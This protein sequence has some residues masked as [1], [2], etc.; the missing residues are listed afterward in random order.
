[1]NPALKYTAV[2]VVAG[3]LL[4][5]GIALGPTLVK[6]PLALAP[7]P[8]R[9]FE[10][11][12]VIEETTLGAKTD[13]VEVPA[14]DDIELTGPE[15]HTVSIFR[16]AS[17][18]VVFITRLKK[19]RMSLD[20]TQVKSGSGS[21]IIWDD[22]GH[23]VTNHHVIEGTSGARVTLAD[24]STYDAKVVGVAPDKDLAV[25]KID[26][27]KGKLRGLKI[28]TS[29]R[30]LVGQH[31]YAIGN[32]FGLDHTLS[33]GVISG[34]NREI[35][36]R[37]AT[38]ITGVV[39]TDA[40]INPGNS[41]GPLLDSGGR[42]IGINT[43]IYSPSGASAGIGFAVPVDTVSRIVPQ[44]I[45]HGKI[46]K[47]GLGVTIADRVRGVQG[48]VIMDVHKGSGAARAGL[49]P[50]L[51]DKR[52]RIRLGDVIVAVNGKKVGE[53]GDLFRALDGRKIGDTVE[54]TINRGD[55]VMKVEVDLSA[56]HD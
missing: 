10:P 43:A 12:I 23:I 19:S 27:P 26:A 16:T 52:G 33:T 36:S 4:G 9:L 49:Q 44:L 55:R 42:L 41:G 2:A 32:P 50:T 3:A 29:D 53:R 13:P 48:V 51:R 30:L 18:S 21:G 37:A 25:L 20:A 24:R 8:D 14:A 31:V 38:P 28:G 40:A 15:Q 6:T 22:D 54:L 39:Q 5:G 45:Q 46:V 17:P 35:R 7:L 56:L 11:P 47:P 1:M 34:L